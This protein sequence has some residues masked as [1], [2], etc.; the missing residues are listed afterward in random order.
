MDKDHRPACDAE[1]RRLL[2]SAATMLEEIEDVTRDPVRA[3]RFGRLAGEIQAYL[4]K[5]KP[6]ELAKTFIWPLD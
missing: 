3:G 4:D 1:A 5:P 2:E 6:S